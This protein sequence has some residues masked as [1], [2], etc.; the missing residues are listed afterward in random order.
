MARQRKEPQAAR[1]PEPPPSNPYMAGLLLG[2]ALTL[3]YAILG[4]GLG[5]SAGIARAA[6][7]LDGCALGKAHLAACEYFGRWGDAP[8]DYYLVYMFVGVFAGGLISAA[9]GGR[10]SPGLERGAS[11]PA[12][13]RAALALFGGILAGFASRMAG[14]CTSGQA[15]SG[16]AMILSGSLVF[17]GACFAGGYA[18]AWF[19]RRQWHD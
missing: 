2:V 16:G 10:F 19:A 3:S 4:V 14:G 17:M 1:P 6:A 18:F 13:R 9:R 11:Y 5:A 15:L 7:W 12:S 8:L